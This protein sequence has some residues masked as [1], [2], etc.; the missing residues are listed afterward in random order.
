LKSGQK[1][2]EE[3]D[4]AASDGSSQRIQSSK[5]PELN[6]SSDLIVGLTSSLGRA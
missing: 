4:S 3:G 5:A 1:V 6:W 2:S